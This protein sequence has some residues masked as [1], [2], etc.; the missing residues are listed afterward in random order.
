[1]GKRAA[2]ACWT[3]RMIC[4]KVVSAP[5]RVTRQ[6][7]LPLLFTLPPV[8]GSPAAL[9]TGIGSPLIMLSST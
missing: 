3:M 8:S 4:D 5:T 6:V 9:A 2:W 7:R 1:M